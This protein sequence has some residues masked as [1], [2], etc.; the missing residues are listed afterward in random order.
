MQVFFRSMVLNYN[1][2]YWHKEIKNKKIKKSP[3]HLNENTAFA[4]TE[5]E[6]LPRALHIQ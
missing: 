6:K 3:R 5:N 2:T 4:D 1:F